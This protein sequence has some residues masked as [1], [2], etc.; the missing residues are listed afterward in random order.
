MQINSHY[1]TKLAFG[2]VHTAVTQGSQVIYWRSLYIKTE[3]GTH[4]I[5]FYG[6]PDCLHPTFHP[7]DSEATQES[8]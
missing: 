8:E 5:A 3:S 6:D 7:T 1:T 4:E 2:P